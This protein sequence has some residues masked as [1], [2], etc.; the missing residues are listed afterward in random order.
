MLFTTTA[1][2]AVCKDQVAVP[3]IIAAAAVDVLVVA[4]AVVFPDVAVAEV[5]VPVV[6][7]I[8]FFEV[9]AVEVL[10]DVAIVLLYFIGATTFSKMA[11]SINSKFETASLN[12]T[13]HKQH[14]V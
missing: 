4:S 11:L 12:D 9:A 3:V 2:Y 1:V 8:V 13:Q 6:I 14:S 5:V 10:F 7:V